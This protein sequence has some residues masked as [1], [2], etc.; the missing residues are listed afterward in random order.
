MYT[1]FC[2]NLCELIPQLCHCHS[3]LKKRTKSYA[4]LLPSW[5]CKKDKWYL[6]TSWEYDIRSSCLIPSAGNCIHSHVSEYL[7]YPIS[8][9]SI[10]KLRPAYSN[11][12]MKW[13]TLMCLCSY[14]PFDMDQFANSWS[15]QK[16]DLSVGKKSRSKEYEVM[17]SHFQR[18]Y[19]HLRSRKQVYINNPEI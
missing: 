13:N 18:K 7:F 11:N 16:I 15:Q 4:M 10:W 12:S 9:K 14:D 2:C 1:V 8:F 17:R 19:F 5:N 6:I 3:L